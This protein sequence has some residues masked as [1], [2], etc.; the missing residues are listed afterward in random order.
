MTSLATQTSQ[1]TIATFEKHVIPN[2]GRFPISLVRGEGSYVWDAEG[3]RYLDL[4]PGW[5]CDILGHCPPGVVQAIRDGEVPPGVDMAAWA[6][7]WCLQ[8]PAVTCVIPGCKSPA[9][10]TSNASA[11]ALDMVRD[12]HPQAVPR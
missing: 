2:Y 3:K 11:V 1:E 9:Q 4:F 10:V 6:L 7:A 12:D 5:G 8:H